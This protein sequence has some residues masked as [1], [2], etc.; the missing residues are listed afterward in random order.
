MQSQ[1]PHTIQEALTLGLRVVCESS[2]SNSTQPLSQQTARL[3]VWPAHDAAGRKQ[4][5]RTDVC[6]Y[7]F[8]PY[9]IICAEP[10]IETC[11]AAPY[12]RRAVI[13]LIC[14]AVC[15]LAS[16]SCKFLEGDYVI[17]PWCALETAGPLQQRLLFAAC[18]SGCPVSP[19][20]LIK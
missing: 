16:R 18:F 3:S 12:R 5:K 11:A 10:G 17:L 6:P 8:A 19:R 14:K 1:S 2:E 15:Q 20:N 13:S 4:T 9:R 7:R